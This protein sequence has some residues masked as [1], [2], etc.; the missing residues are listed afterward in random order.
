[1]KREMT[2]M[3]KNYLK[4]N[5]FL[6]LSPKAVF[7]DMDGVLFDTERVGEIAWRLAAEEMQFL[8]I[9]AA[10]EGCRGKNR[11]DTRE[12]FE[13]HF[14]HTNYQAFHER[15]HAIMDKMLAKGMPIKEGAYELLTWLKQ[16]NWLVALAT[17]TGRENTMQ[18]LKSAE[19]TDF[20]QAIVTGEQVV[21]GKPNPEIYE[22]ACRELDVVPAQ[23]YAIEDS[24]NGISSAAAAK[25]R[26]IM[27]PDLV[28]PTLDLRQKIVA[29]LTSLKDV[30]MFLEKYGVD[31]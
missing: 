12:Y 22:I 5:D 7:F 8:E 4:R 1:M 21:H 17:S 24:P 10:V 25:M 27:V 13:T 19:M 2:N 31:D 23:T 9:D 30:Q 3:I 28:R 11:N 18:H 16:E 15:N 26:V 29:V 20:F 6:E 14:P